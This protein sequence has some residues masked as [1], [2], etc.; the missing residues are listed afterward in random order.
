MPLLLPLEALSSTPQG[1]RSQLQSRRPARD[2]PP[3]EPALHNCIG[4]LTIRNAYVVK[5]LQALNIQK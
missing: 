2:K 5:A 1:P 4:P 3:N